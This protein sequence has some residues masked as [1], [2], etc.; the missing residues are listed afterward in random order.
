MPYLLLTGATGLLGRYLLRD[1]LLAG[2]RVAVVARGSRIAPARRRVDAV[3]SHWDAQLG[4]ALPR[5]VILEGD[6]C[7]PGLGLDARSVRWV[8]DNCN[9]ML[10]SAASLTFQVDEATNEPWR[11]NVEG[12]RN[13]LELCRTA[14]IRKF[15]HVSTAYV[16]GLRKGII[17]EGELDVGQEF[18]NDYEKTKV[19]AEL[20]VRQAEFLDSP[21]F[22]RPSIIVGDSETGYTSTYHGFYTP[23]QLV[24]ALVKTRTKQELQDVQFIGGLNLSGEEKKNFVP[25]DWVS[26][27][28]T[29]IVAH[30]EHHGRTYHL[31]HPE[32]PQIVDLFEALAATTI[33]YFSTSPRT[34]PAVDKTAEYEHLFRDQMRIYEAYWR[35]DPKF[36]SLNT[37]AVAPHL[38]CPAMDGP[39]MVKLAQFAI[40]SNFGWPR[41]EMPEPAF[42]AHSRLDGLLQAEDELPPQD[43][44]DYRLG[45]EVS[46]SGGGQWHLL[47]RG[48]DP[49]AAGRGIH[50]GCSAIYYLNSHTLASLARGDLSVQQAIFTGRVVLEGNG[51]PERKLI[52]ILE[53]VIAPAAKDG[54]GSPAL[55]E[56]FA[57]HLS[58]HAGENHS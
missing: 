57:R 37:Q 34:A 4:R 40:D 22:L 52:Q 19:Q 14:G 33:P 10:H 11:S 8:R 2:L 28:A 20:L 32:P 15:H 39:R 16:C 56:P 41:P 9:A 30:P 29:H 26:S 31:T 44:P 5:P 35:D 55:G 23:L 3:M 45:L 17:R 13:V 24:F 12:T 48:G 50:P 49:L 47:V 43:T 38:P 18:G 42:D 1:C 54:R 25:V 36:D 7:E 46:G 53:Q 6:I 51:L 21:T 27:V 58:V